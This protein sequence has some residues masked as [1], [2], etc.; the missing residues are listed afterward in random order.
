[1]INNEEQLR[2]VMESLQRLGE[3]W[4]NMNSRVIN[5]LN[6]WAAQNQPLIEYIHFVME[7]ENRK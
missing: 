6:D 4:M 2:L 7:E 3:E 5:V 1:M